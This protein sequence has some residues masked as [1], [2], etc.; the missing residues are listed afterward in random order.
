LWPADSLC[1]AEREWC[2]RF[3]ADFLDGYCWLDTEPE[4]ARFRLWPAQREALAILAA[5]PRVVCLKARQLGL[6]WLAVGLALH[7]SL[8]TPGATTL[9]FSRA[10]KESR[11][12]L[13][14]LRGMAERLPGWLRPETVEPTNT[15]E[16][17][18]A[19]GSSVKSFATT[20][21]RS[22]TASLAVVDEADWLVPDERSGADRLPGLLNA[23]QPTVD[24]G[25][26][27]ILL[28]TPRKAAPES[29]F[30]SLYRSARAGG[31]F[32]P[33]FLSWQ[34]RPDRDAAWYG[35]RR[36]ES[37]AASG[38]LDDLHQEYPATEAEALSPRTLDKRIAAAWLEAAY[39]PRTP[40]PRLPPGA[41]AVPGLEV[42]APP[43]PGRRYV[44]GA[45]PAEGNPNSDDS[46]LEVL[47]VQSGEEVCCLAGKIQPEA[48]ADHA[49]AVAVWY[50]R[51]AVLVERNNHGHATLA[52]LR[53]RGQVV[54]L[55]GLDGREGWLSS[56]LGNATLYDRCAEAV[57]NGEVVIHSLS[58][59]SQL[60]GLDG[61]TLA[62]PPG[63]HDDRA[64][65]FA[66]ANA[67]RPAARRPPPGAQPDEGRNV[68][69]TLGPGVW[70][71]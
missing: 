17:T 10:E 25:G 9:F 40:L 60:A 8:F 36:A 49:L 31:P 56:T 42:Y 68:A 18:F 71:T 30:K 1:R 41:P 66:L 19:N 34:A 15:E 14:R 12:L 47:D 52:R 55:A 63:Q 69:E 4:W 13:R 26:R 27:L 2:C 16:A 54:R 44:V 22:Y 50:N 21:G 46:A 20:G 70:L 38:S 29:R 43:Q 32:Q 45:D 53:L 48:L 37:L 28:S 59:F 7:Q 65:A 67:G 6:T 35:R 11:E 64:D 39:E 23:V 58:T 62:A 3:P 33:L 61:S 24:A 5:S 51:A 57:R